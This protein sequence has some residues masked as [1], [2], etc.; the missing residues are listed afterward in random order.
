MAPSGTSLS[1]VSA[2][3]LGPVSAASEPSAGCRR[4]R[5]AHNSRSSKW[6]LRVRGA[7]SSEDERVFQNKRPQTERLGA[8]NVCIGFALAHVFSP[9]F[10][11]IRSLPKPYRTHLLLTSQSWAREARAQPA[12]AAHRLSP[13][14]CFIIGHPHLYIASAEQ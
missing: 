11:Y 14:Q 7:L 9:N 8:Q 10:C 6:R 4:L 12:F 13:A 1:K 5:R 3:L 2:G